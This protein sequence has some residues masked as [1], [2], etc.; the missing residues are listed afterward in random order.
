[1]NLT[2][3]LIDILMPEG[4]CTSC[5]VRPKNRLEP[6]VIDRLRDI[7]HERF[8]D[9]D[10]DIGGVRVYNSS[11]CSIK[12]QRARL[13]AI[14]VEETG[15]SFRFEHRGIPIGQNSDY[16]GG[17][18][19]LVLSPEWRLQ[20]IRIVDPYDHKHPLDESKKQF[21]YQV[22]W[23]KQRNTQMVEMEMRSRHGSFSFIVI[24]TASSVD[25]DPDTVKYVEAQETEGAINRLSNIHFLDE[26]GKQHLKESVGSVIVENVNSSTII[27]QQ[28]GTEAKPEANIN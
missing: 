13:R 24:G 10:L 15:F 16:C 28:G 9:D 21:G 26:G 7:Y 23:D 12:K 20:D 27:V 25:S 17:T 8:S 19:N 6:V 3:V 18:Y 14:K 11:T 4:V 2:I 22:I 1:M 5:T